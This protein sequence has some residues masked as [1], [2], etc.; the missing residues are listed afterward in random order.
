MILRQILDW[1]RHR[2]QRTTLTAAHALGRRGEDLAHRMLQRRGYRVVA[3]NFVPRSGHGD[4][5]LIAWDGDRLVVVEV[6]SRRN[7]DYAE[8]D[9]AMGGDK[10]R[11]L[12]FTAREYAQRANV[13]WEK[14]RFDVVSV[15][16]HPSPVLRHERDVFSTRA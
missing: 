8:P 6:K 14:L 10:Q 15:V 2:K 1:L 7:S 11:R 13:D 9:R 4:I 3:R 5:D 12:K 16:F